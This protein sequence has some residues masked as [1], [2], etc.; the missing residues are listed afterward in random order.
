MLP[1]QRHGEKPLIVALR[2]MFVGDRTK[3]GQ[4][5]I[6]FTI[7]PPLKPIVKPLDVNVGL[8]LPWGLA[9]EFPSLRDCSFSSQLFATAFLL[10]HDPARPALV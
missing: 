7:L 9:D 6:Q 10:V 1:A 5:P 8:V 3:L 4:L 2:G